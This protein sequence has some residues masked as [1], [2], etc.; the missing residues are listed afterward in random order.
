MGRE[1]NNRKPCNECPWR[2]CHMPGWLGGYDV[3]QFINQVN[4]DGPPVPCHLTIEDGREGQICIGAIVFMKN[5]LK[6]PRH[7][8][9]GDLFDEVE[10]D[11]ENVFQWTHEFREHHTQDLKE[12][13]A[14]R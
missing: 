9:Y 4:F 14:T 13:I 3:E 5:S 2:R 1:M 11:T 10:K 8:D 12:W 7:N 6:V